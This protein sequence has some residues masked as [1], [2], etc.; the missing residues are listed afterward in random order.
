MPAV[1]RELTQHVQVDPAHAQ[2]ATPIPV[3]KIV[4]RQGR[5]GSAGRRAG[6]EMGFLHRG[7]GVSVAEV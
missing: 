4:Q 6:L 2:W 3:H 7:D 5:H 1:L